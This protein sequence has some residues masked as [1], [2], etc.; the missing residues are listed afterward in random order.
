MIYYPSGD[1]DLELFDLFQRLTK[2]K[3]GTKFTCNNASEMYTLLKSMSE[4]GFT[5]INGNEC[6]DSWLPWLQL[7]D[8]T[9]PDSINFHS[10]DDKGQIKICR[11]SYPTGK[12][13]SDV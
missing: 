12:E 8:H 7:T 10:K 3:S 9:F 13:L 5:W 4:L 11:G 2:F 1:H 6:A